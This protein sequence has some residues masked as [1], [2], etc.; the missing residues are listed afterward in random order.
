[1]KEMI[2]KDK[3]SEPKVLACGRHKGLSWWVVSYGTHPSAYIN[4]AG[5]RLSGKNYFDIEGLYVHG[6]LTYSA[7]KIAVANCKGWF[8]GW[9]YAHVGDCF[10]G[11]VQGKRW[12]TED[13]VSDCKRA[14]SY[15]SADQKA[16]ESGN[17]VRFCLLAIIAL[18]VIMFFVNRVSSEG[19][20]RYEKYRVLPGD[21]LWDI[22]S[23]F[24]DDGTDIREFIYRIE[25]VND[26]RGGLIREGDVLSIPIE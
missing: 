8:I 21:T 7:E 22:A 11:S 9:D 25:K 6:G 23:D 24:C 18:L 16:Y 20:E 17:I 15:I 12:S 2:Y 10:G 19:A 3:M 14:I 5:T 26:T 1:M 4:V 13:I